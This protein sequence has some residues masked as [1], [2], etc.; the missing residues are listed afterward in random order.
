M[1]PSRRVE[2]HERGDVRLGRRPAVGPA[3][4]RSQDA[5]RAGVLRSAG[6]AA[7]AR[8]LRRAGVVAGAG[9]AAGVGGAGVLRSAGV[10]GAGV[11]GGAGFL[12][13][14]GVLRRAGVAAG[15]CLGPAHEDASPARGV[16]GPGRVVGAVDHEL[17]DRHALRLGRVLRRAQD[18]AAH[19]HAP[20]GE[21]LRGERPP[22]EAGAHVAGARADGDPRHEPVVGVHA[23]VVAGERRP[24]AGAVAADP[25]HGHLLAVDAQLD[26]LPARQPVDVADDVALQA[27]AQLVLPVEG[28]A[29]AHGE[30]A[31]RPERHRLP[32]A[33]VLD[34]RAG[35]LVGRGGR[36]QPSVADRRPAH[37]VG[38]RD[39]ALQERGGD[40][41]EVRVVVESEAQVVGRQERRRVDLQRQ[42]V[43]DGV[44]VLGPVQ[45]VDRGPAGIGVRLRRPVERRL[46]PRGRGVVGGGLRTRTPPRGRHRA[47]VQLQQH[48]L[49][50]V[51]VF[52]DGF[53]RRLVE[54]QVAGAEP[55]VVAGDAVAVEEGAHAVRAFGGRRGPNRDRRCDDD[56]SQGADDAADPRLGHGNLAAATIAESGA[57]GQGSSTQGRA[58]FIAVRFR[59][60]SSVAAD[61]RGGI[62]AARETPGEYR[63][64]VRAGRRRAH[65]R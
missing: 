62:A 15:R 60:D 61:R 50:D 1:L 3:R 63:N 40:V 36:P 64:N 51:R 56:G 55:F 18:E 12:R 49:P 25:E 8:V 14:A 11:A 22:Q 52:A 39:V 42:Q 44:G 43:A 54:G 53:Q 23:A 34:A 47:F 57:D 6:V 2:V 27:D 31:A 10:A 65:S 59:R 5:L 29:V 30:A 45:P 58:S 19:G 13:C 4:Q 28:K 37:L 24:A 9:V 41:E 17:V 33:L 16:T 38:G 48:L 21:A 46:Q 32:G 26:P 20:R 35:D 7:S